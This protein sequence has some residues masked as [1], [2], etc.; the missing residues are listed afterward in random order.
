VLFAHATVAVSQSGSSV[1]AANPDLFDVGFVSWAARE[2]RVPLIVAIMLAA[3]AA[4]PWSP[5][6]GSRPSPPGPALA[7]RWPKSSGPGRR[8]PTEWPG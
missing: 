8:D 6:R 1:G 5:W 3:L 2:D 4:V 7:G